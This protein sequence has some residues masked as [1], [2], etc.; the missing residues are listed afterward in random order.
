MR[1]RWLSAVA[2]VV[3]AFVV[4]ACGGTPGQKKPAASTSESAG[5][6]VKTDGFDS[7]GPVTLRVV[8]SETGEGPKKAIVEMTKAFEQ[9]YPN[10]T[11]KVSYRAFDSWIKQVELSLE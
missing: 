3:L 7:I 6:H 1:V 9:K 8:S 2:L 5:R 10:V 11:V 4:A